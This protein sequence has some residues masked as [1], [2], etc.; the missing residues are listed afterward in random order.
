VD[1][2]EAARPETASYVREDRRVR[3]EGR[4]HESD[5]GFSG[6][7]PLVEIDEAEGGW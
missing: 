6:E 4:P 1:G 3:V 2:D 5:A 7:Q